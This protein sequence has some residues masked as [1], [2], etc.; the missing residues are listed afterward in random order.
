MYVAINTP[1]K[2]L[3]EKHLGTHSSQLRSRDV[4]T[5]TTMKEKK[6]AILLINTDGPTA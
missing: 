4:L 2:T 3:V 6:E 5:V 1:L